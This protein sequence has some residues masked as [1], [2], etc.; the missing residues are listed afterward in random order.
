M[1]GTAGG[2]QRTAPVPFRRRAPAVAQDEAW[3]SFRAGMGEE[4]ARLTVEGKL[5]QG[6][7]DPAA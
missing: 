7:A 3:A 5:R 6:D 1:D 4:M 2:E